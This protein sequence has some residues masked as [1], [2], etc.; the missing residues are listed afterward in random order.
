M[1]DQRETPTKK[2][3]REI[4]KVVSFGDDATELRCNPATTDG[5]TLL[6][7]TSGSIEGPNAILLRMAVSAKT[8]G[9]SAHGQFRIPKPSGRTAIIRVYG[10]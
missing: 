3:C 10:V 5:D 9:T 2:Q 1:Y 4:S 8:M 6:I 7:D